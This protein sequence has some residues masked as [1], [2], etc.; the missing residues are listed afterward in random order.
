MSSK[1]NDYANVT[2]EKQSNLT[3]VQ[4]FS[5]SA[6]HINHASTMIVVKD[7]ILPLEHMGQVNKR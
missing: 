1:Q 7:F 3:G 2:E 5:L 6:I 4:H